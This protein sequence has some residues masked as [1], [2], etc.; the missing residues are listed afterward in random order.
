MKQLKKLKEQ[1]NE[2]FP[3]IREFLNRKKRKPLTK[4]NKDYI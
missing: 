4:E 2:K 1:R 3:L